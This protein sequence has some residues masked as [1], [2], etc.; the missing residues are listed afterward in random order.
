MKAMSA[1]RN[2]ARVAEPP[3]QPDKGVK[4]VCK[5]T[6]TEFKCTNTRQPADDAVVSNFL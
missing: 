3:P 5:N 6:C 4:Q 1:H 2:S